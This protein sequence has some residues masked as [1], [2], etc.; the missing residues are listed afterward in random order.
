VNGG[1]AEGALS[2]KSLDS[3]L[4]VIDKSRALHMIHI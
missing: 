1:V 4:V 3:L 2:H